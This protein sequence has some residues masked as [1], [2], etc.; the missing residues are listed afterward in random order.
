MLSIVHN[1]RTSQHDPVLMLNPGSFLQGIESYMDAMDPSR[2]LL[3]ITYVGVWTKARSMHP[4]EGQG[5]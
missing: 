4:V 3:V 5:S 1:T 2:G